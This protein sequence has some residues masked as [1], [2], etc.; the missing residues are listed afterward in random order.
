[1]PNGSSSNV[2]T[3][4]VT[5]T[6]AAPSITSTSPEPVPGSNSSQT[7]TL[8]GSN[9]ASGCTV[10]LN[11]TT[12]GGTY[13]KSTTFISSTQIAISAN[14]TNA[15]ATWTAKVTN[16]NGSSSNVYT[17]HVTAR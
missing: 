6:A 16:P 5:A 13:T 2:Y 12:N 17:F 10:T 1:N 15:T 4:H 3:F 7:L 9:F 11:D 8:Y 14:F